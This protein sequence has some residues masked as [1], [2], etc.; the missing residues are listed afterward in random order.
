[1]LEKFILLANPVPIPVRDEYPNHF[2][3]SD[4][5]MCLAVN[6]FIVAF[7]IIVLQIYRKKQSSRVRDARADFAE[8][9]KNELLVDLLAKVVKNKLEKEKQE[10]QEKTA[11]ET[12]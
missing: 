6:I 3:S 12:E 10:E 9:V 8:D 1:M 5:S 11:K 7:A 4:I 2:L